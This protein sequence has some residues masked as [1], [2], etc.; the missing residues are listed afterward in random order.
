MCELSNSLFLLFFDL[1]TCL[2]IERAFQLV[3][4]PKQT[5]RFQTSIGMDLT[6]CICYFCLII[7]D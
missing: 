6:H 3:L 4:S 7:K 5:Y 1:A 2:A